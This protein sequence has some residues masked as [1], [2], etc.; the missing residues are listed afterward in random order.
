MKKVNHFILSLKFVK[1]AILKLFLG[2]VISHQNG[3]LMESPH[4]RE[5]HHHSRVI[6]TLIS[7]YLFRRDTSY[8]YRKSHH[9]P[10]KDL[11]IEWN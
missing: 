9:I 11:M 7:L 4:S 6:Y 3:E 2:K 8:D 1:Q 5:K 10:A